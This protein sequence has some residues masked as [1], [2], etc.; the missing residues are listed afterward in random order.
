L[1]GCTIDVDSEAHW[2]CGDPRRASPWASIIV[3]RSAQN[4]KFFVGRL[5]A[6]LDWILGR[7]LRA[8]IED[9][10]S[11]SRTSGTPAGGS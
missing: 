1:T 3:V 8:R 6:A 10:S 5:V 9:E 7:T 4:L 2:A 11:A